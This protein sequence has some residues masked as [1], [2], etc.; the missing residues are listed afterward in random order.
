MTAQPGHIE[1][2]RFSPIDRE[3]GMK[4]SALK[5][6]AVISMADGVQIGR[7]E[8]VLFDTANLRVAALALATSG[9]QSVLPFGSVHR[10][11]ADAVTVEAATAAQPAAPTAP[12]N[13][14]RHLSDMIGLKVVNGEGTYLGDV[15]DVL[16]DEAGGG[17]TELEAHRGGML[18]MGGTSVT[19]PASAVRGIGPDLVTADMPAHPVEGKGAGPSD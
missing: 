3:G 17:L 2:I 7:V 6:M 12:G 10:I 16:I 1:V 9:G 19:V 15:R 13:A 14:L 4:A 11:G 18:G 8:D 5:N